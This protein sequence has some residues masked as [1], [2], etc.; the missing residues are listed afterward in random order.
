MN[1]KE[2]QI[3]KFI[4][5]KRRARSKDIEDILGFPQATATE[6][7]HRLENMGLLTSHS[8]GLST[9]YEKISPE[10]QLTEILTIIKA[11][12]NVMLLQLDGMIEMLKKFKEGKNGNKNS[13][14]TDIYRI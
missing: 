11:N 7:L 14:R 5:N 12:F 1:E 10:I 2:I 4:E 9:Y 6:C 13:A 8:D 3:L